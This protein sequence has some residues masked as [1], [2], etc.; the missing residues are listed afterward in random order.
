[1]AK[2]DSV[3]I[4]R[5][6]ENPFIKDMIVPVGTQN[7]RVSR[8]GREDNVL[9][10]QIT[11]EVHGTHVTA[12]RKVD[13]EEFVKVFTKNIALTFNLKAAGIKAFN[14]LLWSMQK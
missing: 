14:V 12:Y 1:M 6:R 13:K 11:G 9:V 10:N 4:V 3:A 8:L 7:V 2:S 5:Y